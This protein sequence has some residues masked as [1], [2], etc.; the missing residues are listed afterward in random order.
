[1]Q[2]VLYSKLRQKLKHYLDIA[3]DQHEPVI[4]TRG[5]E[6]NVVILSLDDYNSIAETAYLLSTENNTKHLLRSIEQAKSGYISTKEL[7]EE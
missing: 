1:M 3:S 6:K 4:V 7:I 5:D 2:A